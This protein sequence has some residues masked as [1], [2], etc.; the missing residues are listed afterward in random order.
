MAKYVPSNVNFTFNF[1]VRYTPPDGNKLGFNFQEDTVTP[2]TTVKQYVFPNT[3]PPI[4]I[5]EPNIRQGYRKTFAEGFDSLEMGESSIRNKREFVETYDNLFEEFGYPFVENGIPSV[6]PE[7]IFE[8]DFGSPVIYNLLQYVGLDENGLASELFGD[9]LLKGGVRYVYAGDLDFTEFGD[10]K[11][12]NTKADQYIDVTGGDFSKIGDTNV[13]PQ[14][15]SARGILGTLWGSPYVQRNPNPSGWISERYGTAWVS[16]SPRY[17][18]AGIGDTYESGYPTIYDPT[19]TIY[20]ADR[21]IEGGIFGDIR[22]QN[23]NLFIGALGFNS[24]QFSDFAT[25]YSNLRVLQAKGFDS[26]AFGDNSIHNKTPSIAPQGF[27]SLS[28]LAPSVGYAIRYVY[29]TGFDSLKSGIATLTK[30]P[31]I[32]PI[33]FD[34]QGFGT[35]FISNHIRTVEVVGKDSLAMSEPTIWFRYRYLAAVGF[36]SDYYGAPRIEHGR[37]TLLAQGAN[38]AAFGNNAWLSYAVRQL[39]PESIYK[40]FASNHLVGGLQY[41]STQG[42]IATEF[43]TRII[44]ES[45]TVHAQ[46]FSNSFGLTS[47][48]LKTKYIAPQGFKTSVQESLRFGTPKFYNLVQYITQNFDGGSGL[49]PPQWTGWTAIENRNKVIGAIGNNLSHVAEPSIEN[50]ARPILPSGFDDL[51]TGRLLIAD[52]IRHLKPDGLE[53]PYIS[54]WAVVYNSAFVIAPT[55]FNAASFGNH[56]TEKTRRYYER[57]GNWDSLVMGQPMIADRVRTLDIESR[58]GINPPY[59]P[60]PTIDLYTRYI[61]EVGKDDHL[62]MGEP[63]LSIHFNII[64]PRWAHVDRFGEPRLV[65][66]TP[67]VHA[68][69]HNSELFGGASVRTSFRTVQPDGSLM[70]LFGLTGIADRDRAISVN[71]INA[72][73]IGSALKVIKT[74]A[75]PYST[76]YI[77]LDAVTIDGEDNSGHGIGIPGGQVSGPKIRS[78]VITIGGFNNA[79]RF[80]EPSVVSNGIIMDYGI[81]MPDFDNLP[82]VTLKNRM[83]DLDKKGINATITV[84]KPRLSPH[85]I[86]ATKDTPEQ[87]QQN[88]AGQKFHDVNSDGGG[89]QAGEV[90]GSTHI[91][92]Q[93]RVI[94]NASVNLMSKYG[95]AII[96]LKRR[97]LEAKGIQSYRFGWVTV[98]DGSQKI[99]QFA[100]IDNSQFGLSTIANARPLDS[101]ISVRG[102]DSLKIPPTTWASL[103][104]REIKPN[105]INSQRFGI[106][107]PPDNPFMWQGMR[108]G[109]HVLG[110]YGGFDALSIG[111]IFI[112]NK[113]RG[114]EPIGFDAFLCEYDYTNFKDRMRVTRQE[115]VK[116]AMHIAPVGFDGA[117]YAV[118]NIKPAAH[119]IRPDGNADQYRKGGW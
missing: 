105:G 85:T 74:G 113:V 32:S 30:P 26:L 95:D 43:G 117:A 73:A 69:G 55:G 115:F 107:A 13:S 96:E 114:I 16:H 112:S 56:I 83:I 100:S 15:V 111:D 12:V 90:F 59:I 102:F 75:P 98:G 70:Q 44:P 17:L 103:F 87:A 99:V 37:R 28:G 22:L 109:E 23:K 110:N 38:S 108:I 47:I 84:G 27:D 67:E 81:P 5:S 76:Q 49:V 60:V 35:Q 29:P 68:Y 104:N 46:G 88:N 101:L 53:P 80:G 77:W 65:N 20:L 40:E 106:S 34:A 91:S 62:R 61:D 72:G 93:H 6:T 31:T 18:L 71:G 10:T 24:Q 97:Y 116:P 119:Y 21:G 66:V 3:I 57:V 52:R 89:R 41:I 82:T 7:S 42:F 2:P 64:A 25:V 118:P 36:T 1:T 19:Q 78:N 48:D 14:I 11:F 33:G 63:S 4:D 9:S 86:Y 79:A 39:A 92:L 51:I 50:N 94:A 58:Y 8:G 45:Q 54:G